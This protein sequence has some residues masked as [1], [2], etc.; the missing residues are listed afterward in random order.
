MNRPT[1]ALAVA[2]LAAALFG[3]ATAAQ[4]QYQAIAT[5]TRSVG[6]EM[7]ACATAIYASPE[8]ASLRPH[9]ALDPRD[10]TLAQLADTSPASPEEIS[11][12]LVLY[13]RLQQCQ[14]QM[15]DG[16]TRGTPSL[17]PILAAEFVKGEDNVIALIQRKESWGSSQ[18]NAAT[19]RWPQPS[20]SRPRGS[21]SPKA[22]SR[23]TKRSLSDGLR[24]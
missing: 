15:L 20:N 9:Y 14:K 1:R 12:I 23:S 13:P 24:R 4:R 3:C 11:A 17:I 21:A 8:A 22:W 6:A 7:K 5:S 18:N 2:G 10:I 19:M 16:L